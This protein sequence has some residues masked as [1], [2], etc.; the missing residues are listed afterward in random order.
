MIAQDRE[1]VA[2]EQLL[3]LTA[4]VAASFFGNNTVPAAQI[5]DIIKSVHGSL[6]LL[7]AQPE[8]SQ[9]PPQ[10]PAVPVR[11]SV[12]PAYVICLED[13]KKMKMMKRHLRT[14]HGLTPAEYRAKW[15]LPAD[16]PM[17]APSYATMRSNFAKKIGLGRKPN[18][19]VPKRGPQKK[20]AP[21]PKPK[22]SKQKMRAGASVKK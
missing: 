16:Y 15:G 6:A 12:T 21:K 4:K 20:S 3:K 5:S 18:E 7:G 8:A 22:A 2:R 19:T 1:N 9:G 11:R 14:D 10:K 17:V 13:G